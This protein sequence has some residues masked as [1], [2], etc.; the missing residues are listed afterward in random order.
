MKII[1]EYSQWLNENFSIA[2][3]MFEWTA[4]TKDSQGGT[5][6]VP[7]GNT[8]DNDNGLSRAELDTFRKTSA[9][10]I[11]DRFASDFNNAGG[12]SAQ[13]VLASLLAGAVKKKLLGLIAKG[14]NAIVSQAL[15][16]VGSGQLSI[17]Y[18]AEAF[19]Y[20]FEGS[21]GNT[22]VYTRGQTSGNTRLFATGYR[23]GKSNLLSL[24]SFINTYNINAYAL[25]LPQYCLSARLEGPIQAEGEQH[26]FI[27]LEKEPGTYQQSEVGTESSPGILYV[28]STKKALAKNAVGSFQAND[29]SIGGQEAIVSN[30]ETDFAA[31]N[32]DCTTFKVTAAVKKAAHQ[33]AQ[34][35]PAGQKGPDIFKLTSGASADWNG[36][37]LPDST[38]T[39]QTFP[40]VKPGEKQNQQLAY[41][42]GF[43]FM[44]AVNTEL[45]TLGHPGFPKFEVSWVIGNTGGPVK[46][47][48]YVDL[49]L[50]NQEIKPTVITVTKYVSKLVGANSTGAS[51]GVLYE[52]KVFIT[53]ETKVGTPALPNQ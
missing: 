14:G 33:I 19:N 37:P 8:A 32:A 38:G 12:V 17:N 36:N 29:T 41:L 20:N 34:I 52:F 11:F 49:M 21:A 46:N 39:G 31:G 3:S 13:Q 25:N 50:Q 51:T 9:G 2:N 43:N 5:N 30:Y 48:K 22:K 6:T 26:G 45:R 16:L 18:D 23:N 35:W 1:K 44:N 15:G 40:G 28:Y 10:T 24:I 7:A 47:G 42:R 53:G 27:N 4:P